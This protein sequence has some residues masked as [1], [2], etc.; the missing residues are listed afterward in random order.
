MESFGSRELLFHS[1]GHLLRW[2][3]FKAVPASETFLFSFSKRWAYGLDAQHSTFSPDNVHDYANVIHSHFDVDELNTYNYMNE[4]RLTLS[5]TPR[6]LR[7]DSDVSVV[8]SLL[9]R[10][11]ESTY[12]GSTKASSR[13]FQGW[14]AVGRCQIRAGLFQ[15]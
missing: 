14:C 8:S 11:P 6:A 10:I 12:L 2:S 13:G 1:S 3:C 4:M 5:H 7:L 9:P 15:H